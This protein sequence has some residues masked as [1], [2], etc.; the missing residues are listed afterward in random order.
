MPLLRNFTRGLQEKI[1]VLFGDDAPQCISQKGCQYTSASDLFL[2]A[3]Y[4]MRTR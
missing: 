2:Q 3:D 1:F 4:I